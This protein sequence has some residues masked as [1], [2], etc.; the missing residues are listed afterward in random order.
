MPYTDKI[1]ID[2]YD[3]YIANVKDLRSENSKLIIRVIS[4]VMAG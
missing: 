1:W 2:P 4:G 3:D